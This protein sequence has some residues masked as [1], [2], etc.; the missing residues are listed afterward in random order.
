MAPTAP[1]TPPTM[2]GATTTASE[3]APIHAASA[4]PSACSS[5]ARRHSFAGLFLGDLRLSARHDDTFPVV[6]AGTHGPRRT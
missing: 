5:T 3:A 6:Y 4:P 2:A 1:T